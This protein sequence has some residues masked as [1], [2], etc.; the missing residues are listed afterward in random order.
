MLN[1][2]QEVILPKQPGIFRCVFLY[3]GQGESTLL[4]IPTGPL[5]SDYI[6]VL[7]D[8]DQD[9]EPSEIDLIPMLKDLFRDGGHLSLFINTHPHADHTAGIKEIYDEIGFDEVWHSNHKSSGKDQGAF[10]ELEYVIGK[11]G[12]FNEY[13]L[14]GS[15]ELNKIRLGYA[16]LE[17]KRKLGLVDY[18]VLSPAEYVCDD[19]DGE[20]DDARYRRIHEQCGVMRFSYGQPIQSILFTGDSDKKAWQ[21]HIT[22][23]HQ[24]RLPSIILSA[25]HH[26]SRTFFKKNEEDKDV[27]EDHIQHIAPTYLIISAPKQQDSPHDHP[28]DDAMEL[29]RK[30]VDE[31][32]ILHLGQNLESVIV[33][34]S[35][36]G[37]VE[38]RTDKKLVETYGRQPEAKSASNDKQTARVL[39]S[40]GPFIGSQGT[41]FDNKPMG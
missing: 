40:T 12:K 22:D 3:T 32:N 38:V 27:Y 7:L 39:Q 33:D 16:D 11:V 25:S 21:E 14:K 34:I 31:A 36:T 28:H 30:Y 10:E 1:T 13:H 29:Y 5:V 2:A 35:P 37:Q 4:V 17:V 41:K 23:Y 18:E 20:D 6:F 9:K 26:G 24:Q 8:C 15:T 19:I